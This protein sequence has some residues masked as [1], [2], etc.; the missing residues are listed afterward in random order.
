[1]SDSLMVGPRVEPSTAGDGGGPV[2][3]PVVWSVAGSD[4]GGGAGLQ[5]DLRAFDAMGVHGCSVV[6]A[7]TAQNSRAVE[8]VHAV[9]PA[10]LDAQLAALAG[11]L[12]PRVI[13]TG[14]LGSADNVR[15]LARWVDRLRTRGPVALV[16]DPVRR[17]STGALL[18]ATDLREAYLSELVPRATLLTPNRAE[19]AWLLGVAGEGAGL[20]DDTVIDAAARLRRL[21]A[22]SVVVTGGDSPGPEGA[23][24]A[25]DW[26]DTPQASGWLSGTR[27]DTVHNHGT[28]CV[29][30]SSAAG[31]LAHGFCE[32]DALVMA[33]MA[34]AHALT[35]GYRAGA[36]AGP[37][38]P[39][40]QFSLR[41]ELLPTLSLSGR[42]PDGPAFA[43]LAE[44]R[45]GLYAVV[46]S[47]EWVERLLA[48]GV[49]C[50][51]LRIKTDVP[52][53]PSR[54]WLSAEIGRAVRAAQAAG[55]QLFI[56]DH[57]E[58]AL[59][60][61]AYGIHLGQED[62]QALRPWELDR[63]RQ[64]GMRLGISTHSYWEVCRARGVRPS[65]IACGPIHATR[66]KDMPWRPQ[67]PANL[68]YWSAL[69]P[70]PVVAIAGMDESRGREAVQCG[71]AAVAVLRGIVQAPDPEDQVARLAAAL[72]EG[73]WAESILPPW[74]PR[75]T[76][77][78]P[79]PVN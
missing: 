52:Q 17:A 30:A 78:G 50:L 18:H 6:A 57:W 28:G 61:G 29:F 60:H 9:D 67:G 37:V 36:G 16:V 73:A 75:P 69:L 41:R 44:P 48:A 72:N 40:P 70:E 51:Q 13:K 33:K 19:A 49:R 65:Y 55:A 59:A 2:G 63:L 58:L 10:L 27:I 71:A 11:D 54:E 46:D 74:L 68:A 34:T 1:M 53:P 76:L 24:R 31:A 56:N 12:P 8:S 43:P 35:R 38:R 25:S 64:A 23:G 42:E 14:L 66:T 26:I 3:M 15:S 39:G 62:I 22:G 4:S 21:G 77:D 7:L 32:A 20:P 79:V 45:P 47:A 5:A